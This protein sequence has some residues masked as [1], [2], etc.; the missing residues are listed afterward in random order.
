MED[1]FS[2]EDVDAATGS[3][4]VTTPLPSSATSRPFNANAPGTLFA[5]SPRHVA[6]GVTRGEKK[7]E[8]RVHLLHVSNPT[9]VCGGVIGLPEN[10]KFCAVHPNDCDFQVTHRW[11]KFDLQ[12]DTFYIMSPKK[13]AVHAH[14]LPT[15]KGNFVPADVSLSDLL[16]DERPVAMWHVYFDGCNASEESTGDNELQ[17]STHD[18]WEHLQRPSLDE[19]ERANDFKTPKKVRLHFDLE[20]E[21]KVELVQ[22]GPLLSLDL[23]RLQPIKDISPSQT[24]VR[25][26]FVGWE[27]IKNNFEALDK[28]MVSR[29]DRTLVERSEA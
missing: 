25:A 3:G 5:S 11:K 13:G 27:V 17:A 29:E 1:V 18:S 28:T 2:F 14:L 8:A 24:A 26:M 23:T 22:L 20:Q 4:R 9:E 19:L 10:K 7:E 6:S 16:D 12:P 21:V 15:L